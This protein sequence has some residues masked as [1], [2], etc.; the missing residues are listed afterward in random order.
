M[1]ENMQQLSDAQLVAEIM[2]AIERCDGYRYTLIRIGSPK[3]RFII[4]FAANCCQRP[5][6]QHQTSENER[7]RR[8]LRLTT[9][10]CNGSVVGNID[11]QQNWIHVK[12]VHTN[13]SHPIEQDNSVVPEA[14][15]DFIRRLALTTT[16]ADL[17]RRVCDE[18]GVATTRAQVYY[19]REEAIKPLYRLNED[20]MLSSRLLIQQ[21]VNRGFEEVN[22]KKKNQKNMVQSMDYGWKYWYVVVGIMNGWQ[23]GA[24]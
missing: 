21:R 23:L 7:Q 9:Y 3:K 2:E 14:V 13:H 4:N 6:R 10:E 11:R 22:Q 17:Y 16:C 12:V 18:F 5:E 8:R 24:I 15:K 1:D 20:Q 19:W